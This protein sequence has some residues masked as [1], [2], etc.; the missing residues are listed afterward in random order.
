MKPRA[1]PG[2][3]VLLILWKKIDEDGPP[4]LIVARYESCD[5]Q[6]VI[7][8]GCLSDSI[9]VNILLVTATEQPSL[10]VSVSLRGDIQASAV[11]P[12]ARTVLE[13]VQVWAESFGI[14][15]RNFQDTMT[16]PLCSMV[17][18]IS[19]S[20]YLDQFC[21]TCFVS[22]LLEL[23]EDEEE[24]IPDDPEQAL[25]SAEKDQFM[26]EEMVFPGAPAPEAA[27]RAE[28]RRLPQRTRV[29][30]R[31]LHFGH[32]P[33]A[34]LEQ[35]LRQSRASP[36]F[37]KAAKLHRCKVCQ[38]VAPKPRHHPVSSNFNAEFN[39]AI[40]ADSPEIKDSEGKRYTVLNVVDLGTNF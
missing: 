5:E 9:G 20:F 38:D 28:W 32:L 19:E 11:D 39:H 4:G 21:R 31:R 2:E 10:D 7:D 24:L 12:Q 6:L 34:V 40:G 23:D 17:A 36:E 35:I 26:L 25:T 37:T 30:I 13:A 3:Q 8:L 22:D 1:D 16:R 33:G 18:A 14:T 29:A 15:P 27:R